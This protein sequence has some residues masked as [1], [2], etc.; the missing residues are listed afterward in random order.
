MRRN[1]GHRVAA[2]EPGRAECQLHRAGEAPG[3]TV[4]EGDAIAAVFS[5]VVLGIGD[6]QHVRQECYAERPE[7]AGV[8]VPLERMVC[9]VVPRIEDSIHIEHRD[10]S[11]PAVLAEFR[12]IDVAMVIHHINGAVVLAHD[13]IGGIAEQ[14]TVQS[15]ERHL[16][17]ADDCVRSAVV[18]RIDGV[19]QRDSVQVGES[20]PRGKDIRTPSFI[21]LRDAWRAPKRIVITTITNGNNEDRDAITYPPFVGTACWASRR[22]NRLPVVSRPAHGPPRSAR[23]A[24]LGPASRCTRRYRPQESRSGSASLRC[25]GRSSASVQG[26]S[27]FSSSRP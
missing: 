27:R 20:P 19:V 21:L 2:V 16:A 23:R 1:V 6:D 10:L 25:S 18:R 12:V 17:A 14:P 22:E 24:G 7:T 3:P 15:V 5:E 26:R 8:Q 13:E 11:A 9:P 4:D